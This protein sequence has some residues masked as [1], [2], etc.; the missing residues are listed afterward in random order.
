M[1]A[2]R[3]GAGY[4]SK[5]FSSETADENF[6]LM[7]GFYDEPFGDVSALPTN[8]VC[9]LAREKVTVVLTGDG[10]DELFGGYAHY[11]DATRIFDPDPSAKTWLRPIVVTLKNHAPLR[12]I[13]KKAQR[14][15]TKTLV[16]PMERWAK[17]KGGVL[18]TD[19]FKRTWARKAG[20]PADYD[21]YWYYR[22]YDNPDLSPRTRAQFLDF[23]T[24]LHDSVLTKVDR[25]SMAVGLETRVPFLSKRSIATAWSVPEH[26]RYRDGELK[27]LLKR[28]YQDVLPA[29]VLYRRKQGFAVGAIK[30]NA[31]LYDRTKNVPRQILKQLF[32]EILDA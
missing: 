4:H 3:I 5:V 22:K 30:K 31:K 13:A 21:D 11:R 20:I 9:K 25:A 1:V 26:Q 32:S 7:R 18:K 17:V 23:H 14:Y 6:A 19:L 24:Y 27:G 15:E 16:D 29:E 12:L 8:E 2:E 28:L 10:G